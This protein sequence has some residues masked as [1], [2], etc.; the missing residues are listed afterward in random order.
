MNSIRLVFF[1]SIMA[2]ISYFLSVNGTSEHENITEEHNISFK[3]ERIKLHCCCTMTLGI[4][5]KYIFQL[6]NVNI[7]QKIFLK[8]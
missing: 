7:F 5:T 6:V 1:F 2:L 3:L 8:S 4:L